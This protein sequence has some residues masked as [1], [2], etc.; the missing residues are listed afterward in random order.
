MQKDILYKE[1]ETFIRNYYRETGLENVHNRLRAIQ[2]QI[3][4][5]G[6]YIHTNKELIFGGKI[7]WRNDF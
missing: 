5:T 3:S 6:T 7:A 4:Q 2:L 1:A